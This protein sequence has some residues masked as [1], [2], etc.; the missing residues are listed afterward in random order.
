MILNTNR[1]FF[2]K[3]LINS[4]LFITLPIYTQD[5]TIRSIRKVSLPYSMNKAEYLKN[6]SN[7]FELDKIFKFLEQAQK[8]NLILYNNI[9][10]NRK[11]AYHIEIF[12][13]REAMLWWKNH[14]KTNTTINNVGF[15]AAG[16]RSTWTKL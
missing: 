14:V 1:R 7:F 5:N 8:K 3:Y 9:I 2:I 15:Y 6:T 13:N 10:V 12:K 4:N 11:N 16:Y